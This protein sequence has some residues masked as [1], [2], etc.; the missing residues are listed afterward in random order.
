MGVDSMG[1]MI[2]TGMIIGIIGSACCF[3]IGCVM[4]AVRAARLV[5]R[6]RALLN[7]SFS[8]WQI[9]K[10]GLYITDEGAKTASQ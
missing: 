1:Q 8:D 7:K 9:E 2:Q 10:T 5:R 3:L 6:E 4:T